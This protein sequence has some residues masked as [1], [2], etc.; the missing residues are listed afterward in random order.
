LIVE[1]QLLEGPNPSHPPY[2]T[3][4]PLPGRTGCHNE[5][6]VLLVV[7]LWLKQPEQKD[8]NLDLL[9]RFF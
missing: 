8:L 6:L 5:D 9:K 3:P 1:N 7:R 2:K 4:K